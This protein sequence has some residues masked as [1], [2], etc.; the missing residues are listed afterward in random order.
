MT[1]KGQTWFP[2]TTDNLERS[3]SWRETYW[4][5]IP[6]CDCKRQICICP[7]YK[8]V[9]DFQFVLTFRKG[10]FLK[11]KTL[12]LFRSCFVL[13]LNASKKILVHVKRRIK[14]QIHFIKKNV[15]YI[16][17]CVLIFWKCRNTDSED[18]VW[19]DISSVLLISLCYKSLH[20]NRTGLSIS[21]WRTFEKSR[22]RLESRS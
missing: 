20:E 7:S 22:K 17:N 11:E 6:W 14:G 5:Q 19:N 1:L 18:I 21:L 2:N 12:C 8:A 13:C 3:I 10:N 9:L 15:W 16:P 4:I